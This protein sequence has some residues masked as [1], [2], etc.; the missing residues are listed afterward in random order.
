[1]RN[2]DDD[3]AL[4][5]RR[6]CEGVR[7]IQQLE[8]R[9]GYSTHLA[10]LYGKASQTRKDCLPNVEPILNDDEYGVLNVTELPRNLCGIRHIGID[11]LAR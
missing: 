11:L 2:R 5:L 1:M 4:S 8:I 7:L 10:L 9:L 6:H 3:P